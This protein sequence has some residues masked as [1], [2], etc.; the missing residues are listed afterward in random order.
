M[1]LLHK[2]HCVNHILGK[3]DELV[4]VNTNKS[5]YHVRIMQQLFVSGGRVSTKVSIGPPHQSWQS[6]FQSNRIQPPSFQSH[7]IQPP[8]FQSHRIQ[9]PSNRFQVASSRSEQPTSAVQPANNRLSVGVN[10]SQ[11]ANSWVRPAE[12]ID[13]RTPR[14][15]ES[16]RTSM[17]T[18]GDLVSSAEVKDTKVKSVL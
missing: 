18:F 4:Q 11:S 15:P 13:P 16:R 2:T 9:P 8:S 12:Q 1:I 3:L 5:F 17:G 7:R 6:S 14:R 10:R